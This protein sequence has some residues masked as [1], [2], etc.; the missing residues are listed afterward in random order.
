[1]RAVKNFRIESQVAFAL[2]LAA[3]LSFITCPAGCLA[4]PA[5]AEKLAQAVDVNQLLGEDATDDRKAAMRA[6]ITLKRVD[7]QSKHISKSV[8]N[9]A[10]FLQATML[11]LSYP[12]ML[13]D[14][15]GGNPGV[16]ATPNPKLY[17]GHFPEPR[18]KSVVDSVNKIASDIDSLENDLNVVFIAEDKEKIVRPLMDDI[19]TDVGVINKS[20]AAIQ[21]Q[22]K[23]KPGMDAV[24]MVEQLRDIGKQLSN[25]RSDIKTVFQLS[26][27]KGSPKNDVDAIVQ[28]R[29]LQKDAHWLGLAA[30]YL[31]ENV[32]SMKPLDAI[33]RDAQWQGWLTLGVPDKDYTSLGKHP[34]NPAKVKLVNK[35]VKQ[36]GDYIIAVN[37]DIGS[38]EV[39]GS[40]SKD[41]VSN[42]E[43]VMSDVQSR[44]KKIKSMTDSKNY[45][46]PVIAKE[47]EEITKDMKQVGKL[48]DK[49]VRS[50]VSGK[51]LL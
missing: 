4:R 37:N 15:Y 45:D 32:K 8:D 40:S 29:S 36:I 34:Y 11:H 42:L 47:S 44:Y 35:R 22:M 49:L 48:H 21:K 10:S 17:S 13:F 51:S 24:V 26:N 25:I 23:T 3:G 9:L 39:D 19:K 43:E 28:L 33:V 14:S 30:Q 27:L 38:I 18:Y 6:L 46:Q 16:L 41:L 12:I 2:T 7:E 1:M 50:L 31:Q 5:T 20:F